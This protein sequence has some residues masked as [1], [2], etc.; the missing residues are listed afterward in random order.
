MANEVQVHDV[1]DRTLVFD[2][3]SLAA[4]VVE[5]DVAM[6]EPTPGNY[7]GDVPALAEGHYRVNVK[8]DD[9]DDVV[10]YGLINWDGEKEIPSTSGGGIP[11]VFGE[12]TIF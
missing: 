4:V 9:T 6:T 7:I 1:P 11:K 2:V 8:D 12:A 10:G 3:L 5:A